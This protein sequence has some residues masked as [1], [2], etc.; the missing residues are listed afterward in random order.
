MKPGRS[1][2]P[3]AR[4]FCTLGLVCLAPVAS[5]QDGTQRSVLAQQR[6]EV[7]KAFEAESLQCRQRFAVTSC[8]EQAR[9]RR[10]D[11]MA[12]IS[13][14]EAAIDLAQRAEVAEQRRARVAAKAAAAKASAPG[15]APMKP[16]APPAAVSPRPR[17][18]APAH[19]A[20]SSVPSRSP[21][22][23]ARSRAEFES[24]QRKAE[25][26]REAVRVRNAA[27]QRSA[28]PLPDPASGVK[29]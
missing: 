9:L 21:A 13:R 10:R 17:R 14:Q 1:A 26:H 18:A 23:E 25:E 2:A 20:S 4:V 19:A 24:R 6:K 12:E 28:T 8:I 3:W 16:I 11:A 22:Q 5:A 7:Q 15:T 27:R 29:P